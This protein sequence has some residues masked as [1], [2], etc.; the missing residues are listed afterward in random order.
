MPPR[1]DYTSQKFGRLTAVDFSYRE[2][3]KTFWLL[4]CDCG[5]EVVKDMKL[6]KRGNIKSCGCI[7]REKRDITG[8][9]FNKL[10]A[11]K[12]TPRRYKHMDWLFECEC[13]GNII[14]QATKVRT[15]ATKSCGCLHKEKLNTHSII[16][17]KRNT[18]E[19]R[20]L[21][22]MK[23]RCYNKKTKAYKDYGGRGITICERWLSKDGI[24][25]FLEDMGERPVGLSIDR[26]DNDG[27][28]E[29]SNCRWATDEEQA[30][31]RR[32]NKKNIT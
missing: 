20:T 29:P 22:G 26:I 19:Y 7:D 9:K 14:T 11:I 3:K 28:Y 25:N 18:V 8:Q 16:H 5:N 31:N 23:T 32:N 30:N 6:I 10:T 4:K 13:G 12:P 2:N 1:K 24:I 27:N 17:G 21:H 15:G